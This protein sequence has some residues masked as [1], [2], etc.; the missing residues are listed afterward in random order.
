[1]TTRQTRTNR[2]KKTAKNN[3]KSSRPSERKR[4][5]RLWMGIVILFFLC[6]A[7]MALFVYSVYAG[8]WGSLPDYAELRNIRNYEASELYSD[9]G[10]LIGKY[11]IENRT[12]VNYNTISP[13][14]VQALIATEDVRF[15]EHKGIDKIS[16]FRV[17]F[18]TLL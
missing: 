3:S 5:F 11:Y 1:M 9:D 2:K 12:N 18:K 17:F 13:H 15:Y 14:A 7:G 16:L 4:R 6:A 8:L 10:E